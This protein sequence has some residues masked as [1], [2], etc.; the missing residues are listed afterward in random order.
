[1]ALHRDV[2]LAKVIQDWNAILNN[3]AEKQ[4]EFYKYVREEFGKRVKSI[5]VAELVFEEK[6]FLQI[7]YENFHCNIFAIPFG[8]D[9]Y[10]SWDQQSP[11]IGASKA[12]GVFGVIASSLR[13]FKYTEVKMGSAFGG[14]VLACVRTA[15]D[16]IVESDKE[17]LKLLKQSSGM[18]GAM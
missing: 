4:K 5:E 3:Q 2:K 16:R 8:T 6:E 12:P 13:I 7:V 14:V 18:L 1:M 11:K 9:L 10:I 15:A 17:R